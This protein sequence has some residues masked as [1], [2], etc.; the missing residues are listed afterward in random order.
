MGA[1]RRRWR[2]EVCECWLVRRS[3]AFVVVGLVLASCG[4]GSSTGRA[5]PTT[6]STASSGA[7]SSEVTVP[8]SEIDAADFAE[9][10]DELLQM[11]EEDQEERS[12]FG[13]ADAEPWHDEER[14]ARLVEIIDEYGWPT[15]D[16]VGDGATSAAW[17][18]AQ[19]SDADLSFQQRVLSLLFDEVPDYPGKSQQVALLTDRVAKNMSQ[20]QVYGSQ[21]GCVGDQ[22]VPNPDLVQPDRVDQL[23]EQAGLEPLEVYLARFDQHCSD[24]AQ[25]PIEAGCESVPGATL[26]LVPEAVI[27]VGELRGTIES[28][29]FVE[30]LMCIALSYELEVTV[31]LEIPNDETAAVQVFLASNGGS[32][33]RSTLLSGPFWTTEFADGRQSI[34]MLDLLDR[35]RRHTIDGAGL[36]VLLLDSAGAPDRD[37]AM[38]ERL[39]DAIRA[40]PDGIVITLTGN[41]HNRG[42]R[43]ASFD[44]EY[45]PMGYLVKQAIGHESVFALDVRHSGGTAWNCAPDR[46]CGPS[47]FAGNSAGDPELGDAVAFVEV[48]TEPNADGFGGTYFVGALSPAAPALEAKER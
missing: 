4:D 3:V 38:A 36:E 2:G 29:A 5:S 14:T 7:P 23:R 12:H 19:H 48:Y 35:L 25:I 6:A 8:S 20:P 41:I 37:L 43:G 13:E 33:A 24:F 44:R 42:V 46:T 45:E 40:T 22:P 11:F 27:L 1:C 15:P 9:V 21:I 17:L 28:P 31:G 18:I 26:L 47:T 16:L 30:A 34:A 39:L 32:E 10:R